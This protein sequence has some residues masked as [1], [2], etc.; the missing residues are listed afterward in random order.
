MGNW[1]YNPTFRGY[2]CIY[3][4]LRKIPLTIHQLFEGDR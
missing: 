1:G 3:N 4:W 2:N